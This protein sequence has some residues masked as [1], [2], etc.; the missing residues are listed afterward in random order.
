MSKDTEIKEQTKEFSDCVG[1]TIAGVQ[2]FGQDSY[3]AIS[4]TDNT[5]IILG[6]T[7]LKSIS[8]QSSI[9]KL[10]GGNNF[11]HAITETENTR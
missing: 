7:E 11:K 5:F 10:L 2:G 6:G 1:K 4:F 8:Q 3:V 9:S